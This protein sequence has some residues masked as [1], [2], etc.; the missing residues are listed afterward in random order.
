MFFS[1]L[2]SLYRTPINGIQEKWWDWVYIF[3]WIL[4]FVRIQR[5]IFN[6]SWSLIL[7]LLKSAFIL[8]SSIYSIMICWVCFYH[9]R[10][11]RQWKLLWGPKC[12]LSGRHTILYPLHCFF[13]PFKNILWAL[14]V[15]EF[16]KMSH[17]GLHIQPL[18]LARWPVMLLCRWDPTAKRNC[19]NQGWEKFRSL[20]ININTSKILLHHGYA[21]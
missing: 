3:F 6:I 16:I 13:I 20:N 10:M 4:Y 18:I 12:I 7:S 11:F 14:V 2:I 21:K 15:K 19:C 17:L 1:Y 8:L 5:K 9:K